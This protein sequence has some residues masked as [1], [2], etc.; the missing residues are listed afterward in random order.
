MK[1]WISS[2]Q[3]RHR[4]VKKIFLLLSRQSKS[5]TVS[6]SCPLATA[7]CLT[8]MPLKVIPIKK[9]PECWILKKVPVVPNIPGQDKCWKIFLSEEILFRSPGKNLTGLLQSNDYY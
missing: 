6:A 9:F 4:F 1:A 8:F 3:T 5:W 7:P 2:R